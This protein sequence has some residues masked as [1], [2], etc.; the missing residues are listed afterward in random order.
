MN[1]TLI[2]SDSTI[3]R[4]DTPY[5][6]VHDFPVVVVLDNRT[7]VTSVHAQ[8]IYVE[9]PSWNADSF[10]EMKKGGREMPP[11]LRK[12]L[13]DNARRVLTDP[14]A[15][16]EYSHIYA[17]FYMHSP[18]TLNLARDVFMFL[19]EEDPSRSRGDCPECGGT[20][21]RHYGACKG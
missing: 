12:R 1:L 5:R 19:G 10:E 4:I 14:K 18:I 15:G 17:S 2:G 7:Y 6:L 3:R 11:Q 9:A 13:L 16:P 8:G 20:A 21:G